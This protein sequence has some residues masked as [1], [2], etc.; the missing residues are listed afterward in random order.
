MLPRILLACLV[1]LVVHLPARAEPTVYFRGKHLSSRHFVYGE[2]T[3]SARRAGTINLGYAHG[4]QAG[5]EVGVLRRREGMLIPVGILRLV[6]VRPG[7]A[8][9]EY[10]GA[11]QLRRE[12]MVIVSARVLNLWQG[13]TRSDQLVM[14][15]LLSKTG[16]RYDSGD[17]NPALLVEVGRDDGLV[18]KRPPELHVNAD[19][20]STH[21]SIT[22]KAETRG[23]FRPASSVE[24]GLT[25][26]LSLE[27]RELSPDQSTLDLET[28]LSRFVSSSAADKLEISPESLR[29]LASEQ[30][31]ESDLESVR[32]HIDGANARI[33]R[34][35]RPK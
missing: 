3:S 15:T 14:K 12:D 34:L 29:L 21:Q 28:A 16:N 9:G 2:V 4:L 18:A 27:D 8:F 17:V 26:M 1:C 6:E 23:A 11:F 25:N 22:R 20:H 24:D 13:G 31:G 30:S 33:R 5:Q 7:N 35:I 19:I 10:E 32:A